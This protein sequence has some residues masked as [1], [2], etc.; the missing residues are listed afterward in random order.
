LPAFESFKSRLELNKIQK[1]VLLRRSLVAKI[2]EVILSGKKAGNANVILAS[3]TVSLLAT[4]T[5]G[6]LLTPIGIIP[7]IPTTT[8]GSV[9]R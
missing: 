9:L 4:P 2:R 5:T 8:W 1:R 3:L 6:V 7:A